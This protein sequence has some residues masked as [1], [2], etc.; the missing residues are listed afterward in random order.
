MKHV[1]KPTSYADITYKHKNFMVR[2]A[3]L[4]RNFYIK[5]T[6]NSLKPKTIL[7]YGAGDG[8]LYKNLDLKNFV[9]IILFEPESKCLKISKK[10]LK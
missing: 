6:I 5:K 7:D 3:H 8:E 9:K 1:L 10:T 2:F 4:K